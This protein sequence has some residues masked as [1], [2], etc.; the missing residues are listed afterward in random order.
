MYELSRVLFKLGE[1]DAAKKLL[2]KMIENFPTHDLYKK[3]KQIL[4]E[5][6]ELTIDA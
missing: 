3:A 1:L 4:T 5:L 2:T 6:E